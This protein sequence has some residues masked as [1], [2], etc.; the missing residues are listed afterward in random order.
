ML[1]ALLS[2][3]DLILALENEKGNIWLLQEWVFRLSE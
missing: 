1:L 2:K 3:T